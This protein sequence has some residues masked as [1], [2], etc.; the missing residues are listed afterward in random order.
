MIL[1]NQYLPVKEKPRFLDFAVA[2][3]PPSL[4]MTKLA[5]GRMLFMRRQFK[6]KLRT[7]S[8]ELGQRTLVMGVVNVTPDSFSDVG[9]HF[10]TAAAIEHGLRLLDEGADIL[11]IGGESTRPGTRAAERV[12]EAEEL[13]R[14]MPVIEGILKAKP[15]AVSSVDTYK[16]GVAKAACGAGAEIVNDVSA[17]RWDARMLATIAE[18]KCGAVLMHMR[19]RPE[20]WRTLPRLGGDELLGLV[21]GELKLAAQAAVKAGIAKESIVLDPGFGFGKN[22]EENYPLL[23]RMGELSELGFPLLA[24]TSRKGF[25]GRALAYEGKDAPVTDRLYGT[26]ATVVIAIMRGARIVRVHDVREAVETVR[27]VDTV[28]GS[29]HRA[30]GSFGH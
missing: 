24:G 15:E 27:M 19:G 14:V 20:E 3:A 7:R 30:I 4:G 29:G 11:D 25:I 6:W 21:K 5:V 2:D 16:S 23:G 28:I 18:L 22:F 12:P 1:Y 8:V 17:G 9:K 10:S 26:L 13:R